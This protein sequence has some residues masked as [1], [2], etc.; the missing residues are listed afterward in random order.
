MELMLCKPLNIWRT[1]SLIFANLGTFCKLSDNKLK[2]KIAY[3]ISLFIC[4]VL[5]L[6]YY[7]N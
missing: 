4:L 7:N 1:F 2:V 6:Q 3:E 5:H